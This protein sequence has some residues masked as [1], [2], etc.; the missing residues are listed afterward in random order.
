[1]FINYIHLRHAVDVEKFH[2]MK[3]LNSGSVSNV[4][5]MSESLLVE[6]RDKVF[7][8]G[9]LPPSDILSFL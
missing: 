2:R 3:A 6:V 5:N 4:A 8:R 7:T 9:P 1:M